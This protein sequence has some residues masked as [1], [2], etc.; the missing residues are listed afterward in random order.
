MPQDTDRTK[1]LVMHSDAS[2]T[3]QELE[4]T[5][6]QVKAQCNNGMTVI[7]FDTDTGHFYFQPGAEEQQVKEH[8]WEVVQDTT[9]CLIVKRHYGEYVTVEN[10]TEEQIEERIGDNNDIVRFDMN[11]F[12]HYN[13]VT[14]SWEVVD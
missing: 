13:S 11:D 1:C 7:T 14:N 9:K 10:L 5:E 8:G 4:L 6:E 2:F 12:Q 3:I